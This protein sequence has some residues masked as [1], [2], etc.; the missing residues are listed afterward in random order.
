[1][2]GTADVIKLILQLVILG[3]IGGG[4][5]FYY[6][7]LQKNREFVFSI[8][9]Q[10]SSIHTDFLAL[11]YKYNVLFTESGRPIQS[12]LSNDE[13]NKLKWKYYEE[14]CLLLSKFQSLKPLV[15]KYVSGVDSELGEIDAHYQNYRRA[16]RSDKPIFQ[17]EDGKT[18]SG[19]SKLKNSHQHVVSALIQHI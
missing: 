19:L 6:N 11:R 4:V 8:I 14:A 18:G 12:I 7:K 9:N 10:V 13:I 2:M 5:T 15:S 16:I 1:M 3:I 17:S